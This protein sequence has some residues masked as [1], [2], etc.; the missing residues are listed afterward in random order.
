MASKTIFE[1]WV[2]GLPLPKEFNGIGGIT[3]DVASTFKT[4]ITSMYTGASNYGR[5][6]V[7]QAT[8]VGP[9]C[10]AIMAAAK[11]GRGESSNLAISAAAAPEGT[12]YLASY[13]RGDGVMELALF[14]PYK[15]AS[16]GCAFKIGAIMPDGT[17]EKGTFA[18]GAHNNFGMALYASMLP[19]LLNNDEFTSAFVNLAA[20]N[21]MEEDTVALYGVLCDNAYRRTGAPET[22]ARGIDADALINGRVEST[23]PSLTKG[24]LETVVLEP[25]TLNIDGNEVT[26]PNVELPFEGKAAKTKRANNTFGAVR[27][28][29][30][31]IG[32]YKPEDWPEELRGM[33][34]VLGDKEI[35]PKEAISIAETYLRSKKSPY[36]IT[37]FMLMGEAGAGKST[38]ANRFVPALLGMPSMIYSCNADTDASELLVS[39]Q[40]KSDVLGSDGNV[41]SAYKGTGFKRWQDATDEEEIACDPETAW[42]QLTGERCEGVTSLDCWRFIAQNFTNG[43][44]GSA[45]FVAVKSPIVTA[46]ESGCC[47]EIQELDTVRDASVVTA[48]NSLLEEGIITMPNGSR[49]YRNPN[50]LVF[51]TVNQ[52]YIGCNELNQA[53]YDR[54]QVKIQLDTPAQKELIERT[55]T[56]TGFT[57]KAVLTQMA[58]FIGELKTYCGERGITDG[59]VG[60]RSLRN[61]VLAYMFN[62]MCEG[63]I[64]ESAIVTVI[65]TASQDAETRAELVT[66]VLEKTFRPTKATRLKSGGTASATVSY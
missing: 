55:M 40:P 19:A 64:Y 6:G 38:I 25:L 4:P 50:S 59:S 41:V 12:T 22:T 31:S 44:T 56:Q 2:F 21:H 61:W 51:V 29:M 13:T 9:L 45:K 53:V 49:V 28:E 36:P 10:A 24:Y 35:V 23:V 27:K 66:A 33:I 20:Q 37:T 17:F 54:L 30:L 57:D 32:A 15:D 60:Y 16:S 7:P 1:N 14:A 3:F 11:V 42:E 52:S 58:K 39:L 34:P 5:N 8:L 18:D 43:G 65:A 62:P 46:A 26:F 48:L 47:C 63:D